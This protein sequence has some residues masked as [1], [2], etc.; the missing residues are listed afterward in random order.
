[1]INL[2]KH[3]LKLIGGNRGVKDYENM[4]KGELLL[5]YYRKFIKKC[6]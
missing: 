5:P 3:E 6:T 4:S 2:T 1:M